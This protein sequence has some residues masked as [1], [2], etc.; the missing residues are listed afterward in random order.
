MENL[1][2]FAVL[3]FFGFMATEGFVEY[4]LGTLF[5]RITKLTP[6]AWLLMYVSLAGGLFLSYAFQLDAVFLVFGITSATMPWLGVFL[7]GVVIGRGAN[8]VADVWKKYFSS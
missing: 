2:L 8:F 7:T 4:F 6:F 5:E 1:G 3:M